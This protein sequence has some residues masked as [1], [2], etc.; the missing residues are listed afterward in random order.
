MFS[1]AYTWVITGG[2][3]FIGS[4]LAQELVRRGQVVRV[5]DD[6][7]SGRLENLGPAAQS[8]Q[9]TQGDVCDFST[10]EKH[11]AAQIMCSTMRPLCLFR[12]RFAARW[13]RFR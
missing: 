8:V 10:V 4:H 1:R 6:L 3:G 11:S 7:S 9:F 5:L 13:R 12:S 2:A